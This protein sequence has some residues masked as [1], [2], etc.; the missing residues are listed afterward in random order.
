MAY[1]MNSAVTI[2]ILTRD[3]PDFFEKCLK[4]VFEDQ[5]VAPEVIVS[6]NSIQ[7]HIAIRK[8]RSRYPF[9]YVRQSGQ[10]TMT[11]HHNLCLGL[12]STPWMWLVHDDDELY[13]GSIRKVQEFV[14]GCEDVAI[15]LGGLEYIDPQGRRLTTWMPKS[16][17]TFCGEEGLLRLGLDF[18][19]FSP[20]TIFKVA[21]S[22]EIG[23]F[24]DIDGVCADYPLSVRL[25]FSYGVAFFRELVGRFRMGHRQSSDYSTPEKA[26]A[27][28]DFVMREGELMR[29]IGCSHGAAEQIVDY[30]T[31]ETFLKVAPPWLQSHESFVFRLTQ[32]CLRVSPLPGEWQNRVRNQY[33]FL[34]WS[35]PRLSWPLYQTAKSVIPA[36]LRRWLRAQGG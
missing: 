3:R 10:L 8:L 20:G 5:E 13:P 30:T 26:E 17:G 4:S 31:W 15:V 33:P 1:G 19:A 18:G 22:R 14:A 9:S 35:L 6:D 12:P 21:A 29:S 2:V 7:D 24:I 27:L 36:P 34:F 11:E 32:K 16:S 28:L 25:A 23:G